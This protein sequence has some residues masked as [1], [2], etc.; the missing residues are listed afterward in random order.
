MTLQRFTY[1]RTLAA[2]GGYALAKRGSV[3]DMCKMS[4]ELIVFN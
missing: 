2:A 4:S 1:S 3:E